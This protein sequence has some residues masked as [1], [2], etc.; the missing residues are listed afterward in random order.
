MVFV[1][2]FLLLVVGDGLGYIYLVNLPFDVK[3][4]PYHDLGSLFIFTVY[5]T[6]SVLRF[7][8]RKFLGFG[9]NK[10]VFDLIHDDTSL[11]RLH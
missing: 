6:P 8:W 1:V 2:I 3:S 7:L 10:L 4:L 9:T 11:K 5:I